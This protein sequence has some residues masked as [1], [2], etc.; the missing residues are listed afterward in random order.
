[1]VTCSGCGRQNL[2]DVG[3]RPSL[4]E[5]DLLLEQATALPDALLTPAGS[6]PTV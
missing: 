6:D 2:D 4:A 3:A 1:M 5:V